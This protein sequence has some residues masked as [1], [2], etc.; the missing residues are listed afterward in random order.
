MPA[1]Y[2]ATPGRLDAV[3]A[4][5]AGITRADA[6]RAIAAG[7]VT[8]D[9]R[10]RPRSFRLTGGEALAIDVRAAGP[11]VP[12]GDAVPIRYRDQHLVIVAKPAGVLTHPTQAT[13]EDTLVNRLLA[14]GVP[15]AP[16]G[17]PLRPGIVHR[18]DV[19]TSGLLLVASSDD[20]FEALQTML[21]RHEI[22]R[23]YLA[24]VRGAPA[25]DDFSVVA[26][27]GRRAARIVIDHAGGRASSTAFVVR[28]RLRRVT[29]LEA[30][31]RTGRTHQIRV[32]LQAVGHPIVGDRRYGGGGDLARHLGLTRP[33]LHSWRLDLTH[34][35]TGE[36]ITV[37]EP[38]PADLRHALERARADLHP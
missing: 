14:M 15:L 37:E 12:G 5:L 21:R 20:A 19:G 28:E 11:I 24:L 32:H 6:Q 2:R 38:P 31:P 16:A 30:A 29:L 13:R 22:D 23:R 26:P 7:D 4:N 9:G 33:F 18:L 25:N 17:G 27:L 10:T 36:R 8:V 35:V 34:P 3:V 1:E